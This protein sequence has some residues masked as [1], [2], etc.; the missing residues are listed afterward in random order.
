[1]AAVTDNW[2]T[3]RTTVRERIAFLWNSDLLSD[4]KFVVPMLNS[5][6][7]S[8]VIPAHKFVLAI[9]SPVFYAMFYGQ[10]ADT[11]DSIELP[12][13]EYESLLELFRYLYSDEVNLTG[14]NVMLVLYLAKKY[15]VP[16]L[17]DKCAKYL[18]D[19]LEA[20]NVF[21]ILPHA[22][23]FDDK[24]LEERCWEVIEKHTEEAVTSDEFVTLERSLVESVVKRERLSVNEVELFKAVDR[25]ATKESER[26]GVAPDG[27]AKRRILGEELLNEVRFPL[28]SE[29]EFIS[30]VPDSNI[31]RTEEIVDIVKHYNNVLTST[32]KFSVAPR[33]KLNNTL[34]ACHR[35]NEF[36]VPETSWNYTPG[37]SDRICFTVNKNILLKGV[38]HFGHDGGSYT[39]IVKVNDT[40][41]GSCISDEKSRSYS[42][43]VKDHGGNRYYGFDVLFD[44]P[45]CLEQNTC[46]E[47]VSLVS[48]D[49]SWYGKGGKTAAECGG[50][51]FTFS[52]S[53]QKDSSNGTCTLS[54]QFPALLFYTC[55]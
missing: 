53:E 10:M 16:S 41:N 23:K 40:G 14:S 54:G 11:T 42:S 13:C 36:H 20:S 35:F 2:Q 46:Y 43:E 48:G 52:N 29:K 45:I 15:M 24:D 18:R 22:Q 12:D 49:I 27:D 51:V 6:S 38:Q 31:L 37:R 26:Q 3:K 50:V 5:E 44:R 9:S 4:M 34:H 8:K 28:M 21:S 33:M 47:I 30:V 55:C 19:H 32:L 1:M 39:A 25:W 7:E 17:V